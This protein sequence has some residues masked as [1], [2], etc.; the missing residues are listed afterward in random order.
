MSESD[1]I[2]ISRVGSIIPSVCWVWGFVT[3]LATLLLV[4]HCGK[5]EISFAIP[6]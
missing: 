6:K 4:H 1:F 5:F 3:A 2:E